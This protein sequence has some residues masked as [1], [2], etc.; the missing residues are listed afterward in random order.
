MQNELLE[1]KNITKVYSNG[2]MANDGINFSVREGEIHALMGENGAGKSTLMKIL[3]GIEQPDEGEI[4][5][6]GERIK[7]QSPSIAMKH[8]IGMVHQHFML[9][10]SLSVSENM[11]LGVETK[12]GIFLDLE[13]ARKKIELL[14]KKYNLHV[15]PNAIVSELSVGTKQ[16]VEILK[17]LSRGVKILILDEP[18]AVLTPQETEELFQELT[19]L[20]KQGHTIIFISHKLKE[21]K[22]ICDRISIMRNGKFMG[23]YD[24]SKV[25]EKDI[26]KLMV[27]RDVIL[28]VEKK[29]N[30]LKNKVLK[31]RNLSCCDDTGKKLVH[32]V[33]FDIKEGQILGIAGVEGNG[34]KEIVEMLTGMRK[35]EEGKILLN[36]ENIS[37]LNIKNIRRKGISHVPEDRMIHG[38]AGNMSIEQNIISDRY[39]SKELNSGLILRRD[40]IKNLSNRLIKDFKIK[41][42]NGLDHV[43]KLSGGN[44]QKVVVAREFSSNPKLIVVNQPTRGVDVGAI[45]FIR[46]EL[47][48]LR[49][50]GKAILMVSADLN[51][52]LELSDSLIVIYDGKITAYFKD[53]ST[54]TEEELGFYMLGVKKQS[55]EQIGGVID[56]K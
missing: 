20:K 36:E 29:E 2:V 44:I 41:C 45:E 37:G 15:D 6:K 10:P 3:F 12:K 9:I 22:Q 25:S 23:V 34:Q 19:T 38:V 46:K 49:D 21:I 7:I 33:S 35:V 56:E 31:V 30:N 55:P 39:D 50:E 11:I 47:V 26:S 32:D 48:K 8:G 16:K 52:I 1:M 4:L 40:K 18:T 28:Q 17:A 43:G 24:V 53:A 42:S 13:L 54:V 51:E 27:G 5:L 14:C